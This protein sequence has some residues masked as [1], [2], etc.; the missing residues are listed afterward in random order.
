MHVKQWQGLDSLAALLPRLR[1]T[2]VAEL[3]KPDAFTAVSLSNAHVVVAL[4][5]DEPHI[6]KLVLLERS[7]EI[8]ERRSHEVEVINEGKT[9]HALCVASVSTRQ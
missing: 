8:A 1:V 5:E 2:A 3:L 4:A 7:G 6:E 9:L